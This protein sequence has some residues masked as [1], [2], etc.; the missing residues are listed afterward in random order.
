MPCCKAEVFVKKL[1][2]VMRVECQRN[3]KMQHFLEFYDACLPGQTYMYAELM[4]M[5]IAKRV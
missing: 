4:L 2:K 3:K 1:K 5:S